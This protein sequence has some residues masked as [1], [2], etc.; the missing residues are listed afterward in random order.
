M[1]NILLVQ[2]NLIE[3]GEKGGADFLEGLFSLGRKRRGVADEINNA[4]TSK[5]YKVVIETCTR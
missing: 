3:D 4:L 2:I 5:E 1:E